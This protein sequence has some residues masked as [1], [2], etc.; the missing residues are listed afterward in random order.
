MEAFKGFPEG[1]VHLTPI[2]EPFFEQ[3][4]PRINHLGELRLTLYAFW[5]LDH[6]EGVFRYLVRADF[7]QDENFMHSLGKTHAQ[8]EAA[9]DDALQR[10]VARGTLLEYQSCYFLNSP[11]GRAAIRAIESGQWKPGLQAPANPIQEPPNI[12]RLYEENIGPL[13]PLLGEAL[14]EAEDTYPADWIEDAIRIAVE[15]N[16]RNWRYVEA[17]LARWQREGRDAQKTISKDQRDTAEARHRY[18][19]GEF[20]DFVEH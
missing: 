4:L 11:K 8:A 12:F 14:A 17:I 6:V 20:S 2:P 1:K 16:K 3:L 15:K 13:T 5:R 10:V 19:K 7:L 18:T 9:L